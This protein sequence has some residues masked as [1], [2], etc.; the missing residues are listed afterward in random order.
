MVEC[1]KS[2]T[3]TTLPLPLP[4]PKSAYWKPGFTYQLSILLHTQC[5]TQ[6]R[7]YFRQTI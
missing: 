5:L 4:L 7:R 2:C 3:G 1:L 6:P